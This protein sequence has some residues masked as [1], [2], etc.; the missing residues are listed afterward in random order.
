MR[1]NEFARALLRHFS[2]APP[3][4]R[5][6]TAKQRWTGTVEQIVIDPRDFRRILNRNV[7]WPLVLGLLSAVFF[8]AIIYYLLS[9]NRWVEGADLTIRKANDVQK[10]CLDRE[11]GLRGYVIT[12]S[13]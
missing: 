12:G 8:I 6:R 11:T 4:I 13:E 3:L 2:G 7:M 9:V 5:A 1:R 10:V